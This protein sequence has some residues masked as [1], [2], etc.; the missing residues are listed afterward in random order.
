MMSC[1][2]NLC[3]CRKQNLP[4]AKMALESVCSYGLM[5]QIFYARCC[6]TAYCDNRVKQSLSS[7]QRYGRENI[8]KTTRVQPGLYANPCACLPT[9]KYGKN[10]FVKGHFR[11]RSYRGVP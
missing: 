11:V 6:S 5:I 1:F 10:G 3:P 4:N 9:R 7:Y 8:A 2:A